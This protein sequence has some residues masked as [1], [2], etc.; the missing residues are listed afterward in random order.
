MTRTG[1]IAYKN[2]T[3]CCVDRGTNGWYPDVPV[4]HFADRT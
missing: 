3:A 1:S 4:T 2:G